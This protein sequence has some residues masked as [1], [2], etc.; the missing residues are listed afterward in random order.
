MRISFSS[1]RMLKS[2]VFVAAF[3]LFSGIVR[4]GNIFGQTTGITLSD[5]WASPK[6]YAKGAEEIRWMKDDNRYSRLERIQKDKTELNIYDVQSGKKLETILDESKLKDPATGEALTVLRY[7]FSPK[8]SFVLLV[9]ESYPLYRHSSS[10]RVMLYDRKNNRI[11]KLFDGKPVYSPSFSPDESKIAFVFQNNLYVAPLTS[12][13]AE[14]IT[15]DGKK[16]S[17][18]NGMCDWVYEEE[19]SFTKAYEWAPDGNKIAWLRFDESDVPEYGMDLYNSLYPERETFKYPKAGEKNALVQLFIRDLLKNKNTQVDLGTE[20][21]QYIPRIAWTNAGDQLMALRMNR[22]QNKLDFLLINGK[23][24]SNKVL[25]QEVSKAWVDIHE[26]MAVQLYFLKDNKNFIWVSEKDGYTHLYLHSL[27]SGEGQKLTSGN[28][29]VTDFYGVD[30]AM[31]F[32][33]FAAADRSPMERHIFRV[34]LSGTALT[35]LSQDAGTHSAAFSTG[36]NYFVHSYSN[37]TLP[38][39]IVLR[40]RETSEIRVLEDNARLKESLKN[41]KLHKK[42]YLTIPGADG[43]NL[44]AWMIRPNDFDA[45]RKYPVLMYVYGG[46]GSQTVK[47]AWEGPNAFW[48]QHLADKGYIIISVDNRGTGNRGSAFKMSTYRQ[49]GKLEAEDQIAAAN[50]IKN[51]SWADGERIG[52]WGWSFGGYVTALCLTKGQGVFKAGISVAPVTN[53]KYY[54]TIYT[55]RFLQTPQ[56]NESGYE[57]NSP[58]NYAKNLEGRYLLIHGT[59][60]DNV[61]LQNSMDFAQALIRNG[62]DFEM[63]MYPDRNHSIYGPGVRIHLYRKMTKFIEENL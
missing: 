35:P 57:D 41:L 43:T 34:T 62:K 8:E 21:D 60:D 53:W 11:A 19:F 31:G 2:L 61:H 12:L 50:W 52:I 45:S 46:P 44:N 23:D 3:L 58:V 16:N 24:G 47:N 54:D 18:I 17:I 28:W 6:Y 15:K 51:Q 4:P 27:E 14:Q 30:E 29:D 5:I 1:S 63:F 49:L 26:H 22:L 33:Y 39:Q 56:L 55:E 59:A 32:V 37:D 48:Y 25:M 42:T 40:T 13:K 9:T 36:F 20:T 7:E 10:E 38:P